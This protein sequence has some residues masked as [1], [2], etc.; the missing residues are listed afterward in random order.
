MQT[1]TEA[2]MFFLKKELLERNALYYHP[3]PKASTLNFSDYLQDTEEKAMEDLACQGEEE[4]APEVKRKMERKLK[5]ERKKE[6]RRLLREAGVS[7][8]KK[9]PQKALACDLALKYLRMWSEKHKEW[10]FQK[11]RQT[12]LLQHMYDCDQ[13]SDEHFTL[14]LGYLEGLKGNARDLT[15]QKTEAL[16]KES[17]STDDPTVFSQEKIERMRQVLQ[18]LS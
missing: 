4:L 6:E 11:I 10:R 1:N 13:I 12:W 3:N 7:V 2:F 5:K 17:D 16:I 15:I 18:I 14:L 8:E 9:K